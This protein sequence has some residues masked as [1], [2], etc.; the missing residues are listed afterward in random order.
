MK[1]ATLLQ[2]GAFL[3]TFKKSQI[4]IWS[5]THFFVPLQA[6]R[7]NSV[8]KLL[9]LIGVVLLMA[10]SE[11]QEY[12]RMLEQAKTL[13][14]DEPDS[15]LMIIDSLGQHEAEFGKSFRMRY[16]LHRLNAL[17]KVDTL[18]HSAD[19]AR[20]LTDYFDDH[21]TPNEQMLAYYLLGRAYYDIHESPMALSCFQTATERADTTA[22][23]CD[24]RQLSRVYGQMSNIFYQQNLMRQSLEYSILEED[25]AW[26]G[27]DTLNALR[28]VA[29]TIFIYQRLSKTDSAI[30]KCEEVYSQF[31][32]YGYNNYAVSYL[33]SI[34]GNL[35]EEGYMNRASIYLNAYELESG[36]FDASH[37]IEKGR[38][39]YYYNKGLYYM[40][41]DKLDSAEYFFR[42]ELRD[43]KDFNNQNAGSRGLA[44]LYQKRHMPD[45][46]AKY[47]LYS[48]EMNDSVY[49]Q[50]AMQEVEKTR[51]LYD[52]SRNQRIAEEARDK[53]DKEQR[54]VRFAIF[55]LVVFITIGFLIGKKIYGV[56]KK[57]RMNYE[58]KL[59]SLAKTQSEVIQLRA[60]EQTLYKLLQEKENCALKLQ[61][62][63]ESYKAKAGLQKDSSETRLEKSAIYSSLCKL[64]AK[65]VELTDDQWQQVYV[66]VI[67]ILPNFYKLISEKKHELSENEFKTCIL[68]RLHFNPKTVANMVG[69]SPSSITKIRINMMEKLFGEG[70][71]S[72]ELDER[73]M[74]YT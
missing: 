31:R 34:I 57:E 51:A 2:D 35:I 38:E 27:K 14:H 37:N 68:I 21:G 6:K 7:R 28:S 66:M 60:H 69:L 16:R 17:N 62:D 26:K 71:K 10:C 54:K 48:Y 18:F 61:E 44:L 67:D 70:G 50:M 36:Y 32:R 39:V 45:S 56:R 42:K 65:G 25:Y 47:A 24:Y 46:A 63:I 43:G 58:E 5:F 30:L 49:A 55:I 13:M 20:E 52:Y 53:A 12:V 8:K 73:L 3:L 41:I 33:P 19:E 64:A 72:K 9:Y 11:R 23:D 40:S 29:G 15:A 1:S 74:Q 4:Y 22:T 59:S